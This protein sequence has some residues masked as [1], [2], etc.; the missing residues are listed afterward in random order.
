MAS[1]RTIARNAGVSITTVSRVLNN[2][3]QVS[4]GVRQRVLDASNQTGYTQTVGR[5]S[6]TNIALLYTGE[7]SLGSPFDGAIL[8]GMSQGMEEHGYDLMILDARRSRNAGETLTQ[9]ML[10]K[11]IRGA[12]VRTTSATRGTVEMLAAEGFP[13]VVAADRFDDPAVSYVYSDSIAA[14]REATEHLIGL[15]HR[16]IGMCL[17]IVDDSDHLDRL[18][19]FRQAL[20]G[21]DIELDSRD[22][23]RSPANR[24]G[25]VQLLRRVMSRADRPTALFLADPITAVGLLSEAR[26]SGVSIP[27]DLSVVGFDDADLRYMVCPE[28]TAVCQDASAL[29]REAFVALHG[30]LDDDKTPVRKA[31]PTWLEIHGSTA[32][33][34]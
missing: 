24:E 18:E 9:M 15:G 19:G 32:S 34:G 8:A 26:R 22:V 3:P 5:K 16:R 12:V 4:E 29:G 33:P 11:G 30:L 25:G 31:L 21:H 27:A 2:H 14:S 17:N 7:S 23:L 6:T 10:R 20:A 1:V 28:L 13:F